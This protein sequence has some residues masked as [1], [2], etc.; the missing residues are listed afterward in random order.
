[1]ILNHE[2][3]S[4]NNDCGPKS[5]RL[6]FPTGDDVDDESTGVSERRHLEY[7]N[8]DV[9]SGSARQPERQEQPL[10]DP[11]HHGLRPRRHPA[12]CPHADDVD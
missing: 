1:M 2:Y 5:E 12:G 3:A 7:P 8:E 11:G 9:V 10:E 6:S 4:Q